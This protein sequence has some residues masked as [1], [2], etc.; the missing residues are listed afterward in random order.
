MMIAGKFNRSDSSFVAERTAGSSPPW[1]PLGW[2]PILI[3]IPFVLSFMAAFYAGLIFL[4]PF[5][6][7]WDRLTWSAPGG[8]AAVFSDRGV[9]FT[10]AYGQSTLP[11][12]AVE[13]VV[14]V[15]RRKSVYYR[16]V[17]RTDTGRRR[18]YTLSSTPDDEEF[19]QLVRDMGIRFRERPAFW[20]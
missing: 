6:L 7:L 14:R 3:A 18:S 20:F 8:R 10:R 5:L 17:T 12:S 2:I 15:R 16:I 9:H 11:W 19:E 4:L 13:E 1:N